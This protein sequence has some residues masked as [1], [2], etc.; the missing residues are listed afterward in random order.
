[1]WPSKSAL[2]ICL[3]EMKTC[4]HKDLWVSVLG[5]IIHNSPNWKQ[6]KCPPADEWIGKMW[7]IHTREHCLAI[8][9]NKQMTGYHVDEPQWCY[10][11]E[12]SQTQRPHG[13]SFH[14]YV[15]QRQIDRDTKWVSGSLGLERGQGAPVNGH[16]RGIWPGEPWE[17]SEIDL[18]WWVRHLVKLQKKHWMDKLMELICHI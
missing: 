7:W 17:R 9:R 18:S 12:R 13:V 10:N 6:P 1:M 4:S 3:R 16:K 14:F 5:S 8:K 15:Q 11:N 2:N